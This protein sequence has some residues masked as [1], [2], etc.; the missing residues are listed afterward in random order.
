MLKVGSLF[1]GIGG[2]EYGLE[3]AGGFK[4][5]WQ[6]EIDPFCQKVLEKHWKDT[7]IYG[8]I[9]KVDF[10][11]VEHVDV[12][13]GGFPCQDLS[14]A[15]K[16]AGIIEGKRSRLWEEFAR[17]ISEIRP[18]IAIV[19]NVPGLVGWFDIFARPTPSDDGISI[20]GSKI[21]KGSGWSPEI[22]VRIGE[23]FRVE[24]E[25]RQGIAKVIGDFSKIGYDAEWFTLR[26]SDFGAPH[27]RERVFIVA[28]S[29]SGRGSGKEGLRKCDMRGNESQEQNDNTFKAD[30]GCGVIA[31]ARIS[32]NSSS[33]R[34][35]S[36][37]SDR[38]E[39]QVLHFEKR[40]DEE[41]KSERSGRV[42]GTGEGD[43]D[44]TDTYGEGL[45]GRQRKSGERSEYGS[46]TGEMW[47]QN[48]IEVA[49]RFC[50]VDAGLPVELDG[51]K[52]S[53]AGHRVERL[54]S[55]GNAV[56]PAVAEHIGRMIMDYESNRIRKGDEPKKEGTV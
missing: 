29:N 45:E 50:R 47:K 28:H 7:T 19:E 25:Q 41:D 43:S 15:G 37:F 54:K 21:R 16:R 48:W 17:A 56:V 32:I 51:F 9:T 52:L 3:K 24:A 27:R 36:G 33:E 30:K 11:T 10:R 31:H 13:C 26:A 34:C 1:A 44:A 23:V 38:Q 8:D 40:K 35:G 39:R 55:L 14:V 20:N 42:A 12:L 18:R 22:A 6:V 5:V 49:T 53:K 4:T 46:R 2:L